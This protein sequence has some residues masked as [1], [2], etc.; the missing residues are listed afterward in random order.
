MESQSRPSPAEAAAVLADAEAG[1]SS[2]AGRL[3]V[4]R[5]FLPAVGGAVAVQIGTFAAGVAGPADRIWVAV[6]GLACFA[7]V[8]AWQLAAFR[9]ANGVRLGGLLGSVVGG[10]AAAASVSYC[11]ALVAALW[12]AF[13]G[14]W[15]LVPACAL[16]GGLGYALSGRGW[17]RS[18][19]AEPAA[20]GPG[21]S[22]GWLAAASVLALAGLV[23][24]VSLR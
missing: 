12:A 10:T 4:P 11:A 8:G 16:A 13:A 7:A 22:V 5:S 3:V 15:W 19:R 20:H 6:A 23:L 21:P 14:V 18:Y 9:R 1:R 17:M 2:L 24:L